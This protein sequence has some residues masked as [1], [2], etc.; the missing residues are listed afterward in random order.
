[1]R[2]NRSLQRTARQQRGY[3]VRPAGPPLSFAI[4]VLLVGAFS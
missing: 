2:P 1:V 3:S 4:Y